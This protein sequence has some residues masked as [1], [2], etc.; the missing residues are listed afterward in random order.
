VSG[1]SAPAATAVK[2]LGAIVPSSNTAVEHDLAR[3]AGPSLDY[4]VARMTLE[5]TT[6]EAERRML[7]EHAPRAARD[8]GTA[9]V[10]V[11]AF[12]CTSAGALLG[13]AGERALQEDLARRSGAPV[14]STNQAVAWD[15]RRRGARRVAVVTPYVEEL[16]AAIAASLR[17]R[18]FA[19]ASSVGMGIDENFAIAEIEPEEIAAFA[20]ASVA[21]GSCDAVLV[22][23]TNLRAADAAEE[24]ERRLGVPVVTSN[25]ATLAAVRALLELPDEPG[26]DVP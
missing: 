8:L 26:G 24:I 7:A 11:L 6:A 1:V 25:L 10:D 21:P 3:R 14:V 2:R 13:D 17:E 19:V 4:H 15:L 18:G 12:V 5:A 20:A 23:C 9:R 22:S 16:T